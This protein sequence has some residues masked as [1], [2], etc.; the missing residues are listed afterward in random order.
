MKTLD[1][2]KKKLRALLT[3]H[4]LAARYLNAELVT[5]GDSMSLRR[6]RDEAALAAAPAATGG[7]RW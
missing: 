5:E 7:G 1:A 6:T 3:R 2:A 4:G